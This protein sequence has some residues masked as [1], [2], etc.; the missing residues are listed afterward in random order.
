MRDQVTAAGAMRL[1]PAERVAVQAYLTRLTGN[2]HDLAGRLGRLRADLRPPVL[3]GVRGEHPMQH[4]SGF[5][6]PK[7][8]PRGSIPL[9]G[10]GRR[11]KAKARGRG[12][13]SQ[14]RSP[15][16]SS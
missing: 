7:G 5:G 14:R 2:V 13:S 3:S 16:P 15:T 9:R 10:R 8:V 6:E 1:T 12:A 11:V 4:T